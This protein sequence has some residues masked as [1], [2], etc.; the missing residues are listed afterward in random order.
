MSKLLVVIIDGL[1]TETLSC[2]HVPSLDG[3]ARLGIQGEHLQPQQ[4]SPHPSQSY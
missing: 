1:C 2:A 3:L 4:A